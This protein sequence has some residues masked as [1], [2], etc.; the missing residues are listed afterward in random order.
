MKTKILV[1]DNEAPIRKAFIKILLHFCDDNN[2]IFEAESVKTGIQAFNTIGP[3]ILFLDI[4]LDDGT[5]FDLLNAVDIGHT[6]LIFTTAHNQYAIRAF[7]YSAINY[8]LKP[9][10]PSAL[11]KP[12]NKLKQILKR[13]MSALNCKYCWA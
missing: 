10:S 9:I 5:G 4:E 11:Q 6:Q 8:L 7:E 3:H 2:E 1:I 13:P 12:Y